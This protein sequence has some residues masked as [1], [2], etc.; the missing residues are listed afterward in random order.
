VIV[1]IENHRRRPPEPEPPDQILDIAGRG[2]ELDQGAIAAE[3]DEAGKQFLSV[4]VA[5][6]QRR[7]TITRRDDCGELERAIA[8][9]T[10]ESDYFLRRK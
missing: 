6:E 4:L 8:P 1:A 5:E 3:R 7:A 10:A 9:V 2:Q